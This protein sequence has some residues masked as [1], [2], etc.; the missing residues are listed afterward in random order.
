MTS[1]LPQT[2]SEL[3]RLVASGQNR[4]L[5]RPLE[6]IVSDL[7]WPVPFEYISWKERPSLIPYTSHDVITW[8]FNYICP[9]WQN[10]T[11][12]TQVGNLVVC[13]A[14]LTLPTASG[15]VTRQSTGSAS[16]DDE[17]FG[18]PVCEAEAQSLRR[19]ARLFGWCLCL[20]DPQLVKDL[21][22]K[23]RQN[24]R[25][26]NQIESQRNPRTPSRLNN[27]SGNGNGNYHNIGEIAPP[28]D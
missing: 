21:V 6:D 3:K 13:T 27:Y 26:I 4:G 14:T 18:G 20:Y 7:S 25:A 10:K 1:P 16:L 15:P 22:E 19:A 17:G 2:R 24:M 9:G 28:L 5:N 12:I 11:D 8:A 23:K